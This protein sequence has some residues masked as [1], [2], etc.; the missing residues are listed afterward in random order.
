MSNPDFV[1]DS[2]LG[3]LRDIYTNISGLLTG[4]VLAAGSAVI[5][6]VGHDI[7]G[8]TSGS[9]T[10][11]AAGTPERLAAAS[12]GAKGTI[13]QAIPANTKRVAV[14][15]STVDET[16]ATVK[17]NI[18]NPGESIYIPLDPYLIYGD[19]QVNGE[20]FTYNILT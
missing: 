19:A 6:K 20:G 13:V 18:L 14:G 4:I 2:I 5:G 11:D 8:I 10:I 1:D 15:G 17:G 16:A 9:K 12:V 7:T 3:R